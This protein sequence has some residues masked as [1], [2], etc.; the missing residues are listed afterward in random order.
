M[1]KRI[2]LGRGASLIFKKA[3]SRNWS[4][5]VVKALKE[6]TFYIRNKYHAPLFLRGRGGGV[7]INGDIK[8]EKGTRKVGKNERK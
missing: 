3:N 1:E 4:I 6:V 8:K 2:R 7:V 5:H